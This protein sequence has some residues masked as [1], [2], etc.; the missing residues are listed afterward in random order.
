M[1]VVE[2]VGFG[3]DFGVGGVFVSGEEEVGGVGAEG[4]EVGDGGFDGGVDEFGDEFEVAAHVAAFLGGGEVD[5]EV[6][7]GVE[8]GEAFFVGAL[9][10]DLSFDAGDADS[11]E[12]EAAG[13][14]AGLDVW[15]FDVG[16]GLIPRVGGSLMGSRLEKDMPSTQNF[17]DIN[18]L[19]Y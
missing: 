1:D 13:G 16:H 5:E 12:F 14:L 17:E 10:W 15:E 2:V 7:G 19:L 18:I 6:E 11:G 4:F 9:D 8:D 3:F